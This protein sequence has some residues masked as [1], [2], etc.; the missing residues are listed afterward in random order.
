MTAALKHR[1]SLG[2][3][4]LGGITFGIWWRLL[5]ENRFDID[6]PYWHRAVFITALS[7]LNSLLRLHE[8]RRHQA[9]IGRVE[10]TR[11]PLFIL[12]HW[13]GGT[14]HL[15]NLLAK[16]SAQFA[17]ANTF[18]V[19]NPSTFLSTEATFSK[20]FR[21]LV[22]P[23]RPMDNMEMS[24]QAPQEDEFAPCLMTLRSPYPGISFPRRE[25]E[26][27][28]YL[29][30]R[31]VPV[32]EIEQWKAALLWFMKKLTLKY[33]RAL[34][35]KSPPHT[36]R[37]RLLLE[38]F[39]QAR[40]VHIH[41]DPY[42]VFQSHRHYFDTATWYTYLQRPE[43]DKIEE[44][45]LRRY[46]RLYDS[47]FEDLPRIPQGQ[48]HEMRFED[49]ERDPVG[50]LRLLYERL[51]LTGFERSEPELLRYVRSLEGYQKNEFGTL[52]AKWKERVREDW[53]R[54]FE[55]W[56]YPT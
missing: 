15:H 1:W 43:A 14:T 50:Q 2:N 53:R 3:N 8:E 22:P 7:V 35:L 18:Q 30:F 17:Y 52:P 41:R 42:T 11:P 28:R 6:A 38:L 33:D 24:F 56:G 19:V 49:L 31:G 54:S 12:G 46:T 39:P 10:I 47:F 27:L 37:I 36:A 13:R 25:D 34:L 20:W 26:Y 29:D 44:R 9:A 5:R 16:D 48:F 55:L 4:Y 40:F 51:K 45:I 32:Q 23:K 21:G